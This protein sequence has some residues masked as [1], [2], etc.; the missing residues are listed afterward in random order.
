[1]TETWVRTHA[2]TLAPKT[3]Q[4][5]AVLYDMH[6]GPYLGA[7][8]RGEL[9]PELIARWQADRVAAGAGRGRCARR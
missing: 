8:K 7:F 4:T 9:T 2:V 6:I 5:Y 3:A 1:M